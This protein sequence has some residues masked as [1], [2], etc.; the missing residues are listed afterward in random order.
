MIFAVQ[1]GDSPQPTYFLLVFG[2]FCFGL[3]SVIRWFVC[4][5]SKPDPWDEQTTSD[6]REGNCTPICHRCFNPHDP[7]I[8][9]CPECGA[10]VGKYTNMLPFL[11]PFS[12]GHTLRLGTSGRFKRSPLIV[13]GFILASWELFALIAPLYWIRLFQ[14]M[15]KQSRVD[16]SVGKANECGPEKP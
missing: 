5:P 16:A 4:G 11:Y 6:L 3:V 7:L 13:I 9:F 10:P 14:N 1:P 8:N 12:V 15:F 2:V